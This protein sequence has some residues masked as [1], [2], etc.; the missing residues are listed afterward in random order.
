M[1]TCS[2]T[3]WQ[4]QIWRLFGVFLLNQIKETA[5]LEVL[6]CYC[7]GK[8]RVDRDKSS[9]CEYKTVSTFPACCKQSCLCFTSFLLS[10]SHFKLFVQR[11]L[12]F[13][14]PELPLPL[15]NI[16]SD[17]Q[18]AVHTSRFQSFQSWMY[19]CNTTPLSL[20]G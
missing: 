18:S 6:T 12:Y 8:Q 5:Y 16:S 4:L 3:L 14:R 9:S 19:F 2:R 17:T 7:G 15:L 13:C 1:S 10:F 11:R 20:R